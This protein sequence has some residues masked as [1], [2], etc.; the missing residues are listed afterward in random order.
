VGSR[1][2]RARAQAG[3]GHAHRSLGNPDLARTHYE[4]AHLIYTELGMPEAEEMRSHM[5]DVPL[6]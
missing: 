6:A 1:D 3:L 4:R 2:Q 5:C